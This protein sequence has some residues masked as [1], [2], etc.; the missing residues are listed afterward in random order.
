LENGKYIIWKVTFSMN[1]KLS[2]V[3]ER[4]GVSVTT[5][6]RVINNRGYISQ[7]TKKAVFLAM[8]E[9]HYQPNSSARSLK[10]KH[11]NLIGLIFPTITNPFFGELVEKIE[12]KLFEAGYKVILCNSVNNS[13]KEKEYL[14]MLNAN[15]VD[16]IIAGTHNQ[17]IE[18]YASLDLPIV[19]FDRKLSNNIPIISSDNYQGALLA[20]DSLYRAKC[21]RIFFLGNQ[22]IVGNP[23]DL[24]LQGYKDSMKNFNL[25]ENIWPVKF[26]ES[27]SLKALLIRELLQKKEADGIICTDDLTAIQVINAASSLSISIPEDLKVIG[28][29]GTSFIQTY[30]PGLSTIVQPIDDLSSLLVETLKARIDNPEQLVSN[31]V[32]PVSLL[33]RNSTE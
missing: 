16:G 20:S 22:E 10:G 7:K 33:S 9:L 14:Q 17:G 29:D 2:D 15:Q 1:P 23:T 3:A 32:L 13:Q 6:S 4:A 18:E 11:N 26:S 5:A 8:K 19:S 12:S 25:K 28:F 21:R 24:R 31:H 30:F 27:P